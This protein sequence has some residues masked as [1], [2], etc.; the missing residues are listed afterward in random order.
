M[1]LLCG[2]PEPLPGKSVIMADS[3]SFLVHHRQAVLRVRNTLLRCL[4]VPFSSLRIVMPGP[5]VIIEDSAQVER[6]LHIAVIKGLHEQ[7]D[8]R[9]YVPGDSQPF[10]V[11][12]AKAVLGQCVAVCRSESEE[13]QRLG[14]ILRHDLAAK[15][16]LT[17]VMLCGTVALLSRFPEPPHGL[18]HVIRDAEPEGV[19]V[20]EA[21]L[22]LVMPLFGSLTEPENGLLMI[23]RDSVPEAVQLP[24]C[25]LGGRPALLRGLTEPGERLSAILPHAA[26]VT[27]HLPEAVLRVSAAML[28]GLPEPPH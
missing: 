28:R 23:L 12:I 27:V 20:A 4:S 7:L 14:V 3:A 22:C 16:E 6:G 2:L 13:P 24:E 25:V 9:V 10:H 17:H 11:H 18:L 1:P 15:V 21:V 19:H 8:C 26:S 5:A